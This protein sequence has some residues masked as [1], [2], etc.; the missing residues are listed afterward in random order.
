MI[1]SI[2]PN[3]CLT[4]IW[5]YEMDCDRE[6]TGTATRIYVW[7]FIGERE[8]EHSM[9]IPELLW[10]WNQSERSI[11]TNNFCLNCFTIF[12]TQII[13]KCI[14]KNWLMIAT[15]T[16]VEWYVDVVI[17]IIIIVSSFSLCIIKW[18]L[19]CKSKTENA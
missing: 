17:G 18:E 11:H 9:V 3:A 13:V 14:K 12:S 6:R 5:R 2:C 7:A 19:V 4:A 8:R 15:I 10:L 16:N 1:Y